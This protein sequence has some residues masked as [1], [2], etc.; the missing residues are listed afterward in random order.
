M[1][2]EE[3]QS[4]LTMPFSDGITKLQE[5]ILLGL[6]KLKGIGNNPIDEG[7]LKKELST[8]PIE[9]NWTAELESLQKRGF[10]EAAN[11]DEKSS[12]SLTPLGL[13]ILRK[14]EED[15]LQEL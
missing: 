14:I 15:R 4:M 11:K 12:V 8:E 5:R 2:K 9:G 1:D 3:Q 6:W 13:A 7:T 10:L